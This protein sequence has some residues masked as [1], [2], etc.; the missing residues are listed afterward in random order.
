LTY[1]LRNQN[2]IG[3]SVSRDIFHDAAALEEISMEQDGVWREWPLLATDGDM[4]ALL[5]LVSENKVSDSDNNA[6]PLTY[7]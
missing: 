1:C 3:G 7:E 4:A 6:S 5:E 2:A